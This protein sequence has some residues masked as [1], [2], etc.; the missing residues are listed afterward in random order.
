[1]L[2]ANVL[3]YPDKVKIITE[4]SERVQAAGVPEVHAAGVT[5]SFVLIRSIGL[6][7]V[8]IF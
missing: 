2:I 4:E 5:V 6:I 3:R 7:S 8:A 1:M